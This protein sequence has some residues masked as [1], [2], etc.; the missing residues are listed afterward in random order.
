LPPDTALTIAGATRAK[1]AISST[2][3][4]KL[5]LLCRNFGLRYLKAEYWVQTSET[6]ID[7]AAIRLMLNRIA[8]G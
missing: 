2:L 4:L 7:L 6:M 5:P 1:A 3:V 8:P